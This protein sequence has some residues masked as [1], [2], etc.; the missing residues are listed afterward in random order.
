MTSDSVLLIRIIPYTAVRYRT[1]ESVANPTAI[2]TSVQYVLSMQVPQR[3]SH[4]QQGQVHRLGRS[5]GV[6]S[7]SRQIGLTAVSGGGS[8]GGVEEEEGRHH[9]EHKHT[10]LIRS[11]IGTGLRVER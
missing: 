5:G 10:R 2:L 3:Q 9:E 8:S 6:S 11:H 7:D 4:L 1:I